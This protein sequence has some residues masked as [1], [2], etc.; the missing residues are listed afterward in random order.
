MDLSGPNKK[1]LRKAMVSSREGG[2][3][4]SFGYFSDGSIALVS[5]R[6]GGVDLSLCVTDMLC[7][8]GVSSREGGVDLSNLHILISGF[9]SGLLP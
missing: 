6:E 4:L 1:K 5:S 2:V 3:D 8:F 9:K 7:L